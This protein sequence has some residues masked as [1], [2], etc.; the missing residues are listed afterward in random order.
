MLKASREQSTS[1][2]TGDV[3]KR[4]AAFL[5]SFLVCL[6]MAG[7]LSAIKEENYQNLIKVCFF[8]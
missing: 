3:F 1:V 7:L 8:K 6:M 4:F 2:K 5:I